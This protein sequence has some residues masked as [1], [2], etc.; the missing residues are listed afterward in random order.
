M[1]FGNISRALTKT[2]CCRLLGLGTSTPRATTNETK[3]YLNMPSQLAS[4]YF[5]MRNGMSELRGLADW[6]SCIRYS[7]RI[8]RACE[9]LERLNV[10]IWRVLTY[11]TAGCL[12]RARRMR[13][14]RPI[15]ILNCKLLR[16]FETCDSH[17]TSAASGRSLRPMGFT[18]MAWVGM[19]RLTKRI[20]R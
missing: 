18:G 3:G 6:T 1:L 12:L 5:V 9:E 20:V 10:E 14:H 19:W 17:H 7:L 4:T 8:L 16:G 11:V 2:I 15:S 13:W